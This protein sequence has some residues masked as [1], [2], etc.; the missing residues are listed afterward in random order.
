MTRIEEL[1]ELYEMGLDSLIIIA[2]H[3]AW[4]PDRMQDWFSDQERLQYDLGLEFD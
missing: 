3:Y 1:Q 4:N 2:R